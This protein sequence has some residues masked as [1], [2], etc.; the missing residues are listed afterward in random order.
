MLHVKLS[1]IALTLYRLLNR[2]VKVVE[3]LQC[4]CNGYLMSISS[5]NGK[6]HLNSKGILKKCTFLTTLSDHL[7][8]CAQHTL[9]CTRG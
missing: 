7:S 4:L 8:C 2:C 1:V 5:E 3:L 6:T 9:P